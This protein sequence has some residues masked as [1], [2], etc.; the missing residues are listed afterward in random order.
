M[1]I[2]FTLHDDAN[3]NAGG[4]GVV[5][6]LTD[7]YRGRGHEVDFLTFAEMPDRLPFRAKYLLFPEFVAARLRHASVDVIDASCGDAWL[8]AWLGRPHIP[9]G[10][11]LLV[12]RSHGLLHMAD[13][14]RRE[15]AERGGI[16]LSWK[17]PFYWGGVRLREVAGSFRRAD[18]CLFLNDQERDLAVERLG[19]D[20]ARTRVVDNGLPESLLGLPHELGDASAGFGIVH[21]GSYL[22]LKGVRYAVAAIEAI[23][24]RNPEARASF[25]GCACPPE[26][27]L[28]DFEPRH[29][30]RV[31]VERRYE[32]SQ[33]PQILRKESVVLSATLKEGFPLGILEAMACGLPAVTAAT[34]GPLQYVRDGV[35]GLVVPRADAPAL[36]AALERLIADPQLL[37]RMGAAAHETAQRYSWDRI[38]DQTLSAYDEALARRA[39]AQA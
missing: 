37:S 18:L 10:A 7:V 11:P 6:G 9:Q 12:A 3:A 20:A 16:D 24:E 8:W 31:R 38:A 34:P 22:P 17:Y 1:R 5:T 15:E 2:L 29:R 13:I 26:R 21:I 23:F 36:A 27:V 25:L 14:A 33:L 30:R 39:V 35:N 19:V 28:E 32:R 4:M